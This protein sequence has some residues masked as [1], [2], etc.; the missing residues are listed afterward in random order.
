MQVA[1]LLQ[2]LERDGFIVERESD[3]VHVVSPSGVETC[4]LE[5][6]SEPLTVA[7][8]RNDEEVSV[9]DEMVRYL[10]KMGYLGETRTQLRA[11]EKRRGNAA[12]LVGRDASRGPL[13][14]L[15]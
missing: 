8:R 7:H 5:S 13:H 14:L 1:A 12:S 6:K 2:T 10:R 3:V 11:V 4:S 15:R 9:R